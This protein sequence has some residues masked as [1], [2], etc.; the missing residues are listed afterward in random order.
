M[1]ERGVV[2]IW[3]IF[4]VEDGEGRHNWKFL[5]PLLQVCYQGINI[6][7]EESLSPFIGAVVNYDILC[8]GG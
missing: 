8:N 4:N 5:E 1:L 6:L 2:P 7:I 3:E